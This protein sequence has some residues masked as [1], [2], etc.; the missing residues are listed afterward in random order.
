M[1]SYVA[2]GSASQPSPLPSG[3]STRFAGSTANLIVSKVKD[4]FEPFP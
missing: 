4:A 2:V 1:R 3:Q